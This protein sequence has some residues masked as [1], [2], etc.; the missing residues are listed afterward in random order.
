VHARRRRP[1]LN[2]TQA[3]RSGGA[4]H[5]ELPVEEGGVVTDDGEVIDV[6]RATD[7]DVEQ[8]VALQVAR[9]GALWE[10][11]VRSLLAHPDFGPEIF[12]V[13]VAGDRVVSSLCLQSACLRVGGVDIPVGQPEFVASSPTHEHRGLVRA[14]MELVHRWS[15]A[16]GDLAQIVSG[17][18]YFYRRFGYEYAIDLPRL[19]LLAPGVSVRMPEGWSVRAAVPDDAPA[20]VTL[21]ERAQRSATL[22]A[23]REEAWWRWRLD[24][25]W[26]LAS[27]VAERDGAVRGFAD[28]GEGHPGLGESATL[29]SAVAYDELDALNALL[30]AA[31]GR[32][33]PLAIEE[34][35]RQTEP[36]DPLSYR[37][38]HR[39]ALYVRVADP[40]ALLERLRTVLSDRLAASPR[41]GTSGQLLLSTYSFSIVLSYRDGQVVSVEAEPPEQKPD[42]RGGAGVPPDLIATLV[43]GRYGAAGLAA[44][45]DDVRLGPAAD[46]V[47]TLFPRLD[48]DVTLVQ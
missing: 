21:Q 11:V 22:V 9:N 29:V 15:E 30:A 20:I 35:G 42:E 43:L 2:G 8:I 6:R 10:G 26:P 3:A 31:A 5:T 39:Y 27:V 19:R 32:G 41:A 45:H 46:L 28:I 33:R 36:V 4:C 24:A 37:H 14:Q 48:P 34:R 25:G 44:R 40:L 17:I 13:A 7:A 12:T 38:P 1:Q 16:R 23:S 47:E 18:P